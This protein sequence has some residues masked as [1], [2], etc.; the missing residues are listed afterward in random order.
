MD[1]EDDK[2]QNWAGDVQSLFDVHCRPPLMLFELLL[3]DVMADTTDVVGDTTVIGGGVGAAIIL[4]V[5]VVVNDTVGL[6]SSCGCCC[7]C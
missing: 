7:D 2:L 6:A 4:V 1:E 3:L 5:V